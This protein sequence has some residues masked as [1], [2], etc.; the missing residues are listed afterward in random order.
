[1]KH[2]IRVSIYAEIDMG[3]PDYSGPQDIDLAVQELEDE[4]RGNTPGGSDRGL[5][6][7]SVHVEAVE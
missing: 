1:M 2:L 4:F 6:L 5:T 3:D 7:K